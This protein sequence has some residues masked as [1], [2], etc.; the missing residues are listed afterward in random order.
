M[1]LNRLAWRCGHL[2]EA[3]YSATAIAP[4]DRRRVLNTLRYIHA[5]PIAAGVRREFSDPFATKGTT[6][7][8]K[9]MES[10]QPA[11]TKLI[12]RPRPLGQPD[13]EAIG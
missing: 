2:W 12:V 1:A 4:K 8:L 10:L 3:R 11:P 6:A 13:V 9:L 5:N 7:D